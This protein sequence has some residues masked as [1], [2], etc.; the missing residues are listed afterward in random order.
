MAVGGCFIGLLTCVAAEMQ[1]KWLVVYLL[2]IIFVTVFSLCKQ[3]TKVALGAF[4]FFLPLFVMKKFYSTEFLLIAGGPSSAGIFLYDIPLIF[5]LASFIAER[6]HRRD[7]ATHLPVVLGPFILF[8]VWSGFS[9]ANSIKPNLAVIELLWMLKMGVILILLANLI[10]NRNDLILVIV[11]L[12]AGLFLQELVTAS[13]VY[14]KRWYTF[15][16]DVE[17]TTLQSTSNP[18]T[19]RAGGTV[20]WHNVQAAYYA[21]LVPLTAGLYFGVKSRKIRFVLLG[22][23]LGGILSTAFTF[24]R[25]GYLSLGLAL[26]TVTFFAWRKRF[27]NRT[28]L[29]FATWLIIATVGIIMLI[30]GRTVIERIKSK[31]AIDLRFETIKIALNMIKEHPFLGIGLNNFSLA[32]PQE[33]YAPEGISELQQTYIGGEFYGI[34]VHN[35]FLLIASQTGIPCLGFFLLVI[36]LAYR[37]AGKLLKSQQLFFCTLG[38]GMVATLT[39]AVTNMLFDIY[40][41]DLLITV[42]WVLIGLIFAAH[43]VMQEEEMDLREE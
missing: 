15:T 39:G 17:T 10:K 16:G 36:Y 35:K 19:F 3:K 34:A 13:Q 31:V 26:A 11:M 30:M 7:S 41:S 5:L 25:N 14:L 29:L 6:I 38:L 32:M 27:I 43:R 8:V 4:V 23:V 21:L 18:D 40:N 1:L 22:I 9:I 20:G 12:I 28:M 33:E 37:Y 42:F 24:S 2:G